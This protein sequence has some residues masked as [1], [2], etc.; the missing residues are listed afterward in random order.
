MQGNKRPWHDCSTLAQRTH[1][2]DYGD[3][4]FPQ[5]E[6]PVHCVQVSWGWQTLVIGMVGWI[7]SFLGVGLVLVPLLTYASG[8]KASPPPLS[9][10][11][12]YLLA[13]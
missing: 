5:R 2:Q 10:M 12:I 4:P 7:V 3:K 13:T 1:L 11:P 6:L 8:V 9:H